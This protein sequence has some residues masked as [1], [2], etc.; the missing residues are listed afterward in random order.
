MFKG[1]NRNTL[2]FIRYILETKIMITAEQVNLLHHDI[3]S[4]L[5]LGK[6]RDGLYKIHHSIAEAIMSSGSIDSDRLFYFTFK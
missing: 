1:Q 6:G 5:T 4:F 2:Y 3:E